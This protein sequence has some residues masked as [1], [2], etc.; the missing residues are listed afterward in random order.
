MQGVDFATAISAND[1]I[2]FTLTGNGSNALS[3]DSFGAYNVRR[4]GAGPTTGQWQ[5]S[6]DGTVFTNIGS[7]IVWGSGT[8]AAGNAQSAITLNSTSALQNVA[9]GTTI[10]FRLALWGGSGAGTWYLNN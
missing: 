8:T 5:Y 4:S 3:I 1:F 6:T 7:A 10:T 2:T 9:G